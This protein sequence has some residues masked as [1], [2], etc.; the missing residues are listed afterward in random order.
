MQSNP[1]S[2]VPSHIA[3][4]E[5]R[6]YVAN[7]AAYN[8]GFMRGDW[9]T[10][11]V[12]QD[13]LDGFL[14]ERVFQWHGADDEY[15]IHDFEKDG[16]LKRLDWTVYEYQDLDELNALATLAKEHLA[17]DEDWDRLELAIDYCLPGASDA[18]M[19]CNAILQL[20]DM[21]YSPYDLPN[22]V[23]IE[24]TPDREERYGYD[25]INR[26]PDVRH[27]ILDGSLDIYFDFAKYGR[28]D[29]A[30][31]YVELGD[32]GWLDTSQP[33]PDAD[34]YDRYEVLDAAG[35]G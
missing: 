19:L 21:A 29:V 6:V 11:P 26:D 18:L 34:K 1:T 23:T 31:G 16:L 30:S 25:K 5:I 12:S 24:N 27:A 20:D 35:L 8:A 17:T 10:L 9:I 13:E 7:L 28:D 4:Y 33:V 22:N 2:I 14:D 15:A 32:Y 3:P